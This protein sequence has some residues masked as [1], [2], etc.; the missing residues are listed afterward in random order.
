[1]YTHRSGITV[2][3]NGSEAGIEFY[4]GFINAEQTRLQKEAQLKT[5]LRSMGVKAWHPDD[6][7]VDR[8]KNSVKFAYPEYE[9]HIEPGD[10]ICLGWTWKYRLVVVTKVVPSNVFF[11]EYYFR[12][13]VRKPKASYFKRYLL[14]LFNKY[15]SLK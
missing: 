4:N 10:I 5:K 1:M 6:G 7:W 2:S 9:M 14:Y 15:L 12:D 11:S 13:M 8:Q 3:H